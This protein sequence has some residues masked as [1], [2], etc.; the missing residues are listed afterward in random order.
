MGYLFG[1]SGSGGGGHAGSYYVDDA[2]AGFPRR[3]R[4]LEKARAFARAQA[5]MFG[6]RWF[7]NDDGGTSVVGS[8]SAGRTIYPVPRHPR[9]P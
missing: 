7:V 5:R 1:S 9:F 6:K 4:S 8:D 2:S 3:F